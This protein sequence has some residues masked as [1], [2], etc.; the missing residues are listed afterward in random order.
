MLVYPKPLWLAS[1]NPGLQDDVHDQSPL[2]GDIDADPRTFGI[3]PTMSQCNGLTLRLQ[4]AGELSK[5]LLWLTLKQLT[6][7]L[8]HRD[9]MIFPALLALRRIDR[10]LMLLADDIS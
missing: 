5:P 4:V 8:M 2:V 10:V 3:L 6:G 9:D 7:F 1:T